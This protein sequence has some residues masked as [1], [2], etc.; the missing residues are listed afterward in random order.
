MFCGKVDPGQ[1][2]MRWWLLRRGRV[3]ACT[4]ATSGS[5]SLVH[6]LRV[7]GVLLVMRADMKTTK[8]P[9]AY[10]FVMSFLALSTLLLLLGHTLSVFDYGH[11]LSLGLQEGVG[12]GGAYGVL[13][14]RAFGAGDMAVYIPL[15]LLTMTGLALK[16]RWA[17]VSTAAAMG[18]SVYWTVTLAFMMWFLVGVPG[19][20]YA[21]FL[22]F[23]IW[24]L[25]Y[26]MCRGER[27]LNLT[28]SGGGD[29]AG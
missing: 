19:L 5:R 27:L 13:V 14:N 12:G 15:I 23:G 2:F 6:P 22:V 17:Q 28:G 3:P 18:T 7:E 26:L 24:R 8:R 20:D 25:I 29:V 11:T 21:L 16:R 9:V 10:W 4:G 1:R